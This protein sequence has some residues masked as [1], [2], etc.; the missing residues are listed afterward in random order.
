MRFF[1]IWKKCDILNLVFCCTL[2]IVYILI[3]DSFM[4][5]YCDAYAVRVF[6]T[7]NNLKTVRA[8]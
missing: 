2:D 4:L 7:R 3:S 6:I 1:K 8:R 5:Y